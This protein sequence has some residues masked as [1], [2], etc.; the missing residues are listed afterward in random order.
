MV[1]LKRLSCTSWAFA[2][3]GKQERRGGIETMFSAMDCRAFI[4]RSR[5]A[6]VALKRVHGALR[7]KA[8]WTKQERRGGIETRRRKSARERGA[9]EAG[10]P[11]W[12]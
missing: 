7:W 1:A 4:T 12:H 9:H 2:H 6:V 3:K 10:T 11:W 5:N 8:S